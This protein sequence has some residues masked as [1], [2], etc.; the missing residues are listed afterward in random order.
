R[1]VGW[2]ARRAGRFMLVF[3][4]LTALMVWL[5]LRLPTAFLP[6]E[7]QGMLFAMV[8]TPA[9][10]T[11]QRTMQVV[12]QVEQQFLKD[13]AVESL[14]TVQGFSFAG[15]GQNTAIGFVKL[16]D[17]DARA[18]GTDGVE[19]VAGRATMAF[20]GIRDALAFAF[21]PPA[22]QEL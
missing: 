9:G 14:F 19:A 11:Q 17:W 7:A 21:P 13:P 5:F 12:E 6:L 15:A 18:P 2:M 4:V 20:A 10:A 22:V 16:E 1:A 8:Q 3:A